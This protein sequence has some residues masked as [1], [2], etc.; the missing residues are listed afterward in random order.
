M[1]VRGSS[2]EGDEWIRYGS[3]RIGLEYNDLFTHVS[4]LNADETVIR[5]KACTI[6]DNMCKMIEQPE[7]AVAF[8]PKIMPMVYKAS[9]EIPDPEARGVA[10]AQGGAGERAHSREVPRRA[11]LGAPR[12]PAGCLPRGQCRGLAPEGRPVRP[13]PARAAC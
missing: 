4:G 11:W 5:R 10:E 1:Q 12:Q 6:V 3:C 2:S 8:M 7:E 13:R 9:Q